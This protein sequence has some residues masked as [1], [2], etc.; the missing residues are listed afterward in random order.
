MYHPEHENIDVHLAKFPIGA[1]DAQNQFVLL[2]QQAENKLCDE[3]GCQ[4]I[5]RNEA[6]YPS[7]GGFF[8]GTGIEGI[9]KLFKIHRLY[10]AKGNDEIGNEL[11]PGQI[12]FSFEMGI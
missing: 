8:L 9:G 1:V 4:G 7:Q 11:D 12:D 2:G 6:L 5:S 3:I 10:L